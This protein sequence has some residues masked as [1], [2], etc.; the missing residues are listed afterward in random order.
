MGHSTCSHTK[1]TLN[2]LQ[3]SSWIAG[4]FL[5]LITFLVSF[6]TNIEASSVRP[7]ANAI[8]NALP[9]KSTSQAKQ[10]TPGGFVPGKTLGNRSQTD[11]WRVM[12]R[13]IKGTVS[14][15]DKKAGVLIQSAGDS[16]MKFRNND[17]YK[18]SSWTILGMIGTL[19][20]YYLLRGTIRIERGMSNVTIQ[21]FSKFERTG[22]WLNAGAFIILAIT[23]LNM[24]Y[25]RYLL[26]PLLGDELFAT[27]AG[28]GKYLHDFVAFAFVIGIVWIFIAWVRDNLFSKDDIGWIAKAGGLLSKGSHPPSRKFNFGEKIVFWITILGGVAISITGLALL[29]PFQIQLLPGELGIHNMQFAQTW[30]TIIG[31]IM[32]VVVLAH[33][34]LGTIGM[35]GSFQNMKTGQADRN[36][37]LE[38]HSLW[39]EEVEKSEEKQGTTDARQPAE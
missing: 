29:L 15:P 33:I 38:Q 24:L 4:F 32:I 37:A 26:K 1:L 14:I 20:L 5:F 3:S 7:P 39:L 12:R 31:I 19:L 28:T 27:I 30:H 17:L 9:E 8:T 23:G 10:K 25:G 13:N 16:W 35:E 18:Y 6:T 36:W 34:Y 11:L 21:R 22:H 2:F